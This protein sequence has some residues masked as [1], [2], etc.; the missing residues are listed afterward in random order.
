MQEV[1]MFSF[2]AHPT[3]LP[4][5]QRLAGW[6]LAAAFS[7]AFF[8]LAARIAL[9][10]KS[11][12]SQGAGTEFVEAFFWIHH[13]L[14]ALGLVAFAAWAKTAHGRLVALSGRSFSL[15][16]RQLAP[17]LLI[18]GLDLFRARSAFA[19]IGHLANLK[20]ALG[21]SA[22]GKRLEKHLATL[23]YC[24]LMAGSVGAGVMFTFIFA[25]LGV[26]DGFDVFLA[27]GMV[28]LGR[29]AFFPLAILFMAAVDKRAGGL[30]ERASPTF[31]VSRLFGHVAAITKAH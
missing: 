8:F 25:L 18:P 28:V 6:T 31:R 26:P 30:V 27:D 21:K 2:S 11:A 13:A 15:Q 17:A 29:F 4:G 14:W 20:R 1:P 7:S 9:L 23:L 19:E 5:R 12:L 16:T 22:G 24:A 10:G 3:S